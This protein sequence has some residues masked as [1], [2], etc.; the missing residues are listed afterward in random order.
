MVAKP[1]HYAQ[2]ERKGYQE[3]KR[4]G[5]AEGWKRGT[6]EGRQELFAQGDEA[7]V[8][9]LQEEKRAAFKRGYEAGRREQ[10]ATEYERGRKEGWEKGLIEG[11]A[12][13]CN[14]HNT[15]KGPQRAAK[16]KNKDLHG[17]GQLRL[18]LE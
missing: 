10:D 14:S 18:E 15:K 4:V 9:K 5:Y 12:R 1:K 8:R 13:Y 11:Y 16:R 6:E 2:G 7:F 17:A 3:G